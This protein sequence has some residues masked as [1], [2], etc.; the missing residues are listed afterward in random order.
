MAA[1][2]KA[3]VITA[4]EVRDIA[5]EAHT[6][7]LEELMSDEAESKAIFERFTRQLT[8]DTTDSNES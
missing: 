7:C 1:L 5:Q 8:A 3:G 4:Q 6:N 2:V